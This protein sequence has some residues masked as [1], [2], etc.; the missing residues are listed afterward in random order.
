MLMKVI[1]IQ[2]TIL[3]SQLLENLKAIQS[4]MDEIILYAELM[5]K[6]NR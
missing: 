6:I 5:G 4:L 2:E 3:E 1:E